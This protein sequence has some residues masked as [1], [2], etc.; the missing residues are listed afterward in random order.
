MIERRGDQA[1]QVLAVLDSVAAPH[2]DAIAMRRWPDLAVCGVVVLSVFLW[3]A[4]LIAVAQVKFRGDLRGLLFLGE[5]F[6]HPQALADVPRVGRVGYDGQFYAAIATDP[7]LRS[8]ETLKSLDAPA[9]RATRILVPM[10]AWFVS[11]GRPRAAVVAYQG[12]CWTL[13]IVAVGVVAVWLRRRG[14]SPWWALLLAA[15]AGLVTAMFRTTLDGAAVCFVVATLWLAAQDRRGEGL[16]AAAA[17]D[18]C[19]ESSCI[20]PLALVVHQLGERRYRRALG[21]AVIPLI[22]VIA[23]QAYMQAVWHPNVRLPASVTVPVVA[24]AGKL[25]AV[26][27]GGHLLPSP[28]FWGTLG[29]CLTVAAGVAVA[30]RRR[31]FEPDRLV[32]IAFAVL[33]LF[34]APRAYADA[35]GFSRHLIVAPF[36]AVPVAAGEP[37]R[38]L[39]ALLISGP[40]A[41]SIT[42]LLMIVSE[43]RPFFASL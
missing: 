10:V 12:L 43:L 11:L 16:A 22:P 6:Y 5:R 27:R 14:S 8:P 33:A 1:V 39:R 37:N 34:L 31:R 7:F 24:L 36:L 26:L 30:V 15:N 40:L 18:L 41:F 4:M 20:V 28:E 2:E 25:G 19:R 13:S 9:Y 17:G 29:V 35:Y 3:A 23:W 42:G 21:Y 38:W 32:F